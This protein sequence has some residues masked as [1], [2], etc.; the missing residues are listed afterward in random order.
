MTA[1]PVH[2]MIRVLDE[3]RSTDFYRCAFGL[4]PA[5]RFAFDAFTLVYLRNATSPFEVELTVNHGRSEPYA[6][7]DGYGHLAVTVG[8]IGAEHA[9]MAEAG[10]TPGPLRELQHEG[11][12]LARFFFLSDPDGYRIE[13]IE[14]GG[15][16]T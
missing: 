7:G 6:L 2:S 11:Q 5:G 14:R 12:R 16:F 15:R 4:E 13:V 1:K 9:R 8:D 10:L 3:A